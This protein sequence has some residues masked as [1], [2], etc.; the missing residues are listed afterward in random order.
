MT[1]QSHAATAARGGATKV[2]PI[3][4][5]AFVVLF[6]VGFLMLETPDADA[7]D[8]K[9]SSFWQDSGHRTN[10]VIAS[11]L[12]CLAAVAFLWL[13]GALRRRLGAAVGADAAYA[14]GIAYGAV[15]L[16]AGFGRGIIGVGHNLADVPIPKDVDLL[17]FADGLYYGVVFLALPY[18]I[19]ASSS[20]CSSHREGPPCCRGGSGSSAWLSAS[21]R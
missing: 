6:V 3:A 12:T 10:A 13:A 21:W 16:M 18:A 7:S 14:G 1:T 8:A 17:K 19:A 4:G 2:G 11:I 9:W 15:V 20:R 5:I